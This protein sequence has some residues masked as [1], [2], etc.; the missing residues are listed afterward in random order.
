VKQYLLLLLFLPTLAFGQQPSKSE[1]GLDTLNL[2]CSMTFEI[3]GG[4][5]IE[6]ENQPVTLWKIAPSDVYST[7]SYREAGET[8]I[9]EL[10]FDD[11]DYIFSFSS[12]INDKSAV[13]KH[14]GRLNRHTLDFIASSR[15]DEDEPS[16]TIQQ[17]KCEVLGLPKI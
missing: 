5:K 10:S 1:G 16:M 4:V 9:A 6:L 17:G 13:F 2:N 8:Y 11:F 7:I 15:S 14:W 3:L 12:K